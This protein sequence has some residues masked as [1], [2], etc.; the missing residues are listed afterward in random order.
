[1]AIPGIRNTFTEGIE[2]ITN[3]DLV[4]SAN[5]L[6]GGIDLD[7]ASSDFANK[8][9]E[10]KNY[11]TPSDDGLNEQPWFDSVYLFPPSGTYFWDLKNQKWKLTRTSAK[12]LRSSHAV[13]FAKLYKSWLLNEIEQGLFFTNCPDIIRYDQKI[14]DFPVCILRV[15]PSLLRRKDDGVIMHK[16]A[17]SVLVYLQPK[18]RPGEA[19][20]K[21]IDIYSSKGRVLA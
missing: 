9:V 20:Q 16:T 4:M 3:A 2:L 1:M 13:W 14:F 12:S 17:T 6:L 19:T 7:P 15:C 5:E 18:D 21:F 10:A 11:Y 8:Y